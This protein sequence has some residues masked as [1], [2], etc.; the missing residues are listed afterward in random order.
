MSDTAPAGTAS[1]G[2]A[3][4]GAARLR[5]A[6]GTVLS[7]PQVAA[8]SGTP[9]A[10]ISKLLS[11]A[12]M[13]TY[14]PGFR[15]TGACRSEITY[16]DG[17][18]GILRYR[19]YP[20]EQLAEKSAFTEVTYLLIH[21]GLPTTEQLAHFDQQLRRHAPLPAATPGCLTASVPARTR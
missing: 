13:I 7:L 6:A 17:D 9:G 20:I 11:S 18:A 10:D 5:T 14:D 16:I 19:G 4:D 8:T 12:K 15:N 21:G 2:T 1:D 3:P